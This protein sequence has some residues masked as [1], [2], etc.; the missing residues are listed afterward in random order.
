MSMSL[1]PKQEAIVGESSSPKRK[2]VAGRVAGTPNKVTKEIKDMIQGAL[3]QAGGQAYLYQ[4]ALENP[5]AFMTLIGKILPKN[6]D[7]NAEINGSMAHTIAAIELI[8][9]KPGESTD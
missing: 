5:T 1:T 4:Q 6:I 8:G 7:V 9:V 3:E 2:K